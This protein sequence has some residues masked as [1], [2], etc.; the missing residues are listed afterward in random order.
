MYP[1]K[2]NRACCGRLVNL[3][4][5]FDNTETIKSC[6]YYCCRIM[7]IKENLWRREVVEVAPH[8]VAD[9]PKQRLAAPLRSLAARPGPRS[10][11]ESLRTCPE[12]SGNSP[13]RCRRPSGRNRNSAANSSTLLER[14]P[15]MSMP[16]SLMT[17]IASGRTWLGF[18]PALTTSKRSPASCRNRPSAIW[19]APNFPC[20]E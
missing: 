7:E 8:L 12:R 3:A 2:P 15:E 1:P 18:V 10:S 13:S 19:L 5:K 14:W 11:G 16:S 9:A 20:T 17:A 6:Q 4:I